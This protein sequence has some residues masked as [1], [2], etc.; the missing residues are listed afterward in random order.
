MTAVRGITSRVDIIWSI[1]S[2]SNDTELQMTE[3]VSVNSTTDNSVMYADTFMIEVSTDDEDREYLC[4]VM[5]NT[6]P[7]VMADNSVTLDVMS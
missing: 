4:Q 3:G 1:I 5:I 6:S 2:S 7:P